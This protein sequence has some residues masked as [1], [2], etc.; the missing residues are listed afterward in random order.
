MKI[1][2]LNIENFKVFE[3]ASFDLSNNNLIV[4]DGP[5]GFGKTSFYDALE[6]LFTGTIRRYEALGAAIIHGQQKHNEYPF[7]CDTGDGGP[8]SI[9]ADIQRKDEMLR[10]SRVTDSRSALPHNHFFDVFKFSL[11][12][13]SETK[14]SFIL[15]SEPESELMK[16]LLGEDYQQNFR[17]LHYIEQEEACHFLRT[18]DAKRQNAIQYLFNTKQFEKKN[19]QIREARLSMNAH[20]RDLKAKLTTSKNT[21]KSIEISVQGEAERTPYE[22]IFKHSSFPFDQERIDF[23]KTNL[24]DLIGEKGSLSNLSK[25]ILNRHNFLNDRENA[26]I[27]KLLSNDALTTLKSLTKHYRL[28]DERDNISRTNAVVEVFEAHIEKLTKVTPETI[29]DYELETPEILYGLDTTLT[30]ADLYSQEVA[31]PVHWAPSPTNT[32]EQVLTDYAVSLKN[33]KSTID[34]TETITIAASEL[35][36]LRA[37]LLKNYRKNEQHFFTEGECVFCGYGWESSK[38]LIEQIESKT[39]KLHLTLSSSQ[40]QLKESMENFGRFVQFFKKWQNN[41]EN[42]KG[43]DAKTSKEFLNLKIKWLFAMRKRLFDLDKDKFEPILDD[44][45]LTA[46]QKYLAIE[47][48]IRSLKTSVS[49]EAI[50]VYFDD[51]YLKYFEE[52]RQRLLE[53]D[54]NKILKKEKYLNWIYAQSQRS[55]IKT[56]RKFAKKLEQ[57]IC[58]C[59]DKRNQLARLEKIYKESIKEYSG[60]VIKDIELLFHVYSGRILQDSQEG[61]GLFIKE[62][63]G[64]RILT[65][66]EKSYDALFSMSTGQLSGLIIAFTMAL[67]KMY[68]TSK[69]LF[70]DDPVQTMDEINVAGFIDL[71]RHEFKDYQIILSTHE[72]MMSSYMRY[73]FEKVG[74]AAKK[75]DMKQS[76]GRPHS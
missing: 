38:R 76:Y 31:I 56:E 4:L 26:T 16:K 75:I 13:F 39:E 46:D 71:L 30:V 35:D 1:H 10:I 3:K 54:I 9:A 37:Q 29:Q 59:E 47:T 25:F 33:I 65:S 73:K 57:E 12:Q 44:V 22:A 60:K 48:K 8:I 55:K 6:L 61:C 32:I 23:A 34:A 66:P 52:D 67:N 11:Y 49:L 51:Y 18:T 28:I 17:Y 45:N 27:Q 20:S 36:S 63:K 19:N 15:A 62:E 14:K 53:F 2:K 41:Y 21:V 58:S 70:I 69:L 5:N 72:D 24:S 74:L 64:I 43:Y 7:Y 40:L 50:E 68:S 42:L